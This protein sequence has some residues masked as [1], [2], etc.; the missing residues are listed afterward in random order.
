[1]YARMTVATVDPD[2][3]EEARAAVEEGFFPAAQAQPGY[4]GFLVLSNRE[5]HQLVGISLWESEAT[6]EGSS[7][8]SGYFQQR[9]DDFAGFVTEP[10]TITTHEVAVRDP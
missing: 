10:P 5:N 1:M 3:F 6:M 2:H 4:A 9:M 8:A 7:G